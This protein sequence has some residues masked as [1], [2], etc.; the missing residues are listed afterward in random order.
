MTVSV[1]TL[2]ALELFDEGQARVAGPRRTLSSKGF[3]GGGS[4]KRA[5]RGDKGLVQTSR[6]VK[7]VRTRLNIDHREEGFILE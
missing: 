6:G 5:T 1:Q 3:L 2:F 7:K 4:R